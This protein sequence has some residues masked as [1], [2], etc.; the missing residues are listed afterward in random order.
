MAGNRTDYLTRRKQTRGH[1]DIAVMV[2]WLAPLA[3]HA[4]N[5]TAWPEI[6]QIT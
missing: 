5:R 3:K 2:L 4:Q 6:E 1:R